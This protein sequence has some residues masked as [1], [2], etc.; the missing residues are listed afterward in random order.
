AAQ[1]VARLHNEFGVRVPLPSFFATPTIAGLAALVESARSERTEADLPRIQPRV[2]KDE[3]PLSFAQMRLWFVDLIQPGCH[4]YNVPAA[5]RISRR[6]K[7]DVLRRALDEVLSR[8]E[9]LRTRLEVRDG[10]P[11][12]VLENE[13]KIDMRVEDLREWHDADREREAHR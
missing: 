11:Y 12:A 13:Q 1:V 9:S 5:F 8:H 10:R 4:A 6:L 3:R 7:D 2:N